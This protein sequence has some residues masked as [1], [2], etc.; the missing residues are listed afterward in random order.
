MGGGLFGCVHRMGRTDGGFGS[1]RQTDMD[2]RPSCVLCRWV[3]SSHEG[4]FVR[5]VDRM[6]WCA[7]PSHPLSQRMERKNGL[8]CWSPCLSLRSTCLSLSL[9]LH[10]TLSVG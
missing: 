5:R 2:D 10:V 4:L 1:F 7:Y 6:V 3:R 8:S 9:H